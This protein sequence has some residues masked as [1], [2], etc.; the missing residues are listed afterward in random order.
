ML[1]ETDWNR[2]DDAA[3][4]L[5]WLTLHNDNRVWRQIDWFITDRLHEKG[6]IADPRTRSKSLVLTPEGIARAEQLFHHLFDREPDSS[7]GPCG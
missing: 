2:V 6:L 7:S 3:L 4:A 1:E 5:L